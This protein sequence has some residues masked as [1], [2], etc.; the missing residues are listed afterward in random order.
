VK[1]ATTAT[2]SALAALALLLNA[3]VWGLSWV[4]FKALGTLGL[5]PLWSTALFHALALPVLMVWRPA[6]LRVALK[7][8][9]LWL[10]AATAG[11]TNVLFNWAVTTGDVVRV[12]LLFYLLPVWS[13]G[14]AWWLLGERPSAAAVLR[15]AMALAGVALV[16]RAPDSP[17]PWPA[18]GADAL[19]LASG[20]G[21]ALTTILLR[22]LRT[23]SGGARALAMF[24]GTGVMALAFA[25]AG[26]ASALIAPLPPPQ[27][28]ALP[29][30]LAL[31]AGLL[32]GN[33][34]LQYGAARLPAQT[35]AL[36]ML[37]EVVITSVS[38]VWL[39]AARLD[40]N[41]LLGGGIILLAAFLAVAPWRRAGS[42]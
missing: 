35:T 21:A 31:A 27:W 34:A 28:M 14:F 29:W 7:D 22:R 1:R 25:L 30:L 33:Y 38:A 32:A 3:T 6:A 23:A 37:S 8:S 41:V 42:G 15:L 19:A 39:G 17:W 16:L 11:L 20:A 2:A 40:A 10:L 9:G 26:M 13:V 12:V 24:G 18:S 4:P 36:I 5:H